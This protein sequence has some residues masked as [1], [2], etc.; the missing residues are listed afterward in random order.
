MD[1]KTIRRALRG[2]LYLIALTVI[3]FSASPALAQVD[4]TTDE[5]AFL[6]RNPDLQFQDFLG[7]VLTMPEVCA[8]PAN[9]SSNDDCFSPGQILSDI[10][11]IVDPGLSPNALVLFNGNF[12]GNDNQP[13]VLASN[14]G[15]V[16]D[17]FDI[18]FTEPNI[19]AVGINA[20]CL[21]ESDTCIIGR[22]VRVSVFGGSGQLG[23]IVIPVTS[24][25]NSFLGI[26]TVEP[27]TEISILDE[28]VDV[29]QGVLNVWF[30]TR[31][32]PRIPTLSEW[33]M[34]AAAAGLMLV[35]VFYAVKRRRLNV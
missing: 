14:V 5:A 22:T 28:N 1:S 17:D 4:F 24:A 33:G 30:G 8:N 16:G 20:G 12:F 11:F 3:L 26:S 15:G 25:F 2:G 10:E 35:G 27:I 6:A 21:S 13:N 34:I 9:S 23:T 7:K 32:N 18:I 31:V 29:I 19:N